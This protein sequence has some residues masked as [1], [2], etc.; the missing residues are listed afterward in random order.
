MSVLSTPNILMDKRQFH[1]STAMNII[2]HHIHIWRRKIL[3][4]VV[5]LFIYFSLCLPFMIR[6]NFIPFLMTSFGIWLYF[7]VCVFINWRKRQQIYQQ[8]NET[9]KKMEKKNC[10]KSLQKS[11]CKFMH[12]KFFTSQ[13]F[14]V[15]WFHFIVWIFVVVAFFCRIFWLSLANIYIRNS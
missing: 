6:F 3:K 9:Y 2:L 10:S 13:N 1:N 8:R 15:C 11:T 14:S 7:L 5:I 4:T 12:L